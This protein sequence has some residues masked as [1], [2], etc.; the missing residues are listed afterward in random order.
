M[1]LNTNKNKAEIRFIALIIVIVITVIFAILSLVINDDRKLSPVEGGIKDT[2]LSIQKVLYSPFRYIENKYKGTITLKRE[3]K[4]CLEEN[5]VNSKINFIITENEELKRELESMKR[6][7][8]MDN[9]FTEYNKINAMVINRDVSSWFNT[10]TIDK[11]RNHGLE[12][13]MA[14]V[15]NEGLV[16]RIIKTS[17]FTSEVKLLTT[18]DL[19]NKISVAIAVNEKDLT[20]GLIGGYNSK[21]KH[22]L[23]EGII[24]SADIKMD[25]K[26]LTSGYSNIFPKGIIIGQVDAVLSDGY[27]ISKIIHVRP[28]VSFNDIRFVSVLKRRNYNNDN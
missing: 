7:L 6:L 20:Y 18:P 2:I 10:L 27:G 23:I 8:E 24:D 22:L 17:Y 13:D 28:S 12:N 9:L 16:G 26:V 15:V 3:Y 21:T 19:T 14:V 11:G 5:K 4:K 25:D 1:K